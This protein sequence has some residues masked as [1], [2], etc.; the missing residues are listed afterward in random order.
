[1]H[2]KRWFLVFTLAFLFSLSLAAQTH[3]TL[4]LGDPVYLVIEQAQMRGLC[5]YLPSAKPY[6]RVFVASIIEEIFTKNETLKFGK[7]TDS[8]R[9]ILE[10]FRTDINPGK[11]GLDL[12]RG[13]YFTDH[14]WDE[15]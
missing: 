15:K 13:A 12:V 7:L 5:R 11:K 10:Q 1:M 6:S 2:E 8:E 4:P 14:L 3:T 9:K